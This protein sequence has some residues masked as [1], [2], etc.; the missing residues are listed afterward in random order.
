MRSLI[1]SS[2]KNIAAHRLNN[3]TFVID[4]SCPDAAKN[5]EQSMKRRATIGIYS[6][7]TKFLKRKNKN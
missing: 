5:K 1:V 7:I 2:Y 4:Y 6:L 3:N